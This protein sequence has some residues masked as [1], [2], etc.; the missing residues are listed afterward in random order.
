MRRMRNTT[1][2]HLLL[3]TISGLTAANSALLAAVLCSAAP[4]ALRISAAKAMSIADNFLQK[5]QKQRGYR[6]LCE[7]PSG[8]AEMAGQELLPDEAE[9]PTRTAVEA[10][11]AGGLITL[12]EALASPRRGHDVC[13]NDRDQRLRPAPADGQVPPGPTL[14]KPAHGL[15]AFE[16]LQPE[17][18]RPLHTRCRCS[19]AS[20]RGQP[21]VAGFSGAG[22]SPR[23]GRDQPRRST[24]T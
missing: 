8:N 6:P 12:G 18:E 7:N 13:A 2:R 11:L 16:T 21:Q 4:P 1:R 3:P 9:A 14:T 19:G 23:R 24:G 20:F 17:E 5:Q 15:A 10:A 22:L